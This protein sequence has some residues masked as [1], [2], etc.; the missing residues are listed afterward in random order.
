MKSHIYKQVTER[1]P[2]PKQGLG[3]RQLKLIYPKSKSRDDII[4]W[5]IDT[6]FVEHYIIQLVEDNDYSVDDVIQDVYLS[7]L[8]KTQEDWDKLT[9]QGYTAIRAYISGMI[10]R[11]IKSANSP[12]YYQY[13]RYNSNR[14][15]IDTMTPSEELD[16]M[17]YD[18]N[19]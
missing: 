3:R 14:T 16:T 19:Q 12:S 5:I 8:E 11:Q 2:L 1:L 15:S 10:Y 6:Q 7:L 17:L 18:R 4:Q 9:C 13:R